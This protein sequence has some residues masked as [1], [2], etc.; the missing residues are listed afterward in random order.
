MNKDIRAL[1]ERCKNAYDKAQKLENMIFGLFSDLDI[2]TED[3]ERIGDMITTYLNYG[4]IEHFDNY[5]QLIKYL[6]NK[7][8]VGEKK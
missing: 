5:N 1:M 3:D 6:R 8:K 2:D 7:L 4:D